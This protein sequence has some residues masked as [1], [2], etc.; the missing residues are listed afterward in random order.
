MR[1]L[2]CRMEADSAESF[3]LSWLVWPQ[4]ELGC[5][6]RDWIRLDG[7]GLSYGFDLVGLYSAGWGWVLKVDLLGLFG[8]SVGCLVC[9]DILVR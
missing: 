1:I 6:A 8:G 5:F 7:V 4:T 3:D 9:I 2:A